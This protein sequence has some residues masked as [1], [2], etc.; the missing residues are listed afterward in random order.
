MR[1]LLHTAHNRKQGTDWS[2]Q[3]KPAGYVQ[4]EA[5]RPKGKKK[6]WY[7]PFQMSIYMH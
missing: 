3:T 5:N 2:P 4:A 6:W 7:L 1:H